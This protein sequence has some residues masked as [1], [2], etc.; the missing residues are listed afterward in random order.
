MGKKYFA[1]GANM[2]LVNMSDRCLDSIMSGRCVLNG[3]R[4]I[5]N[6][7]GVASIVHHHTS[8]VYGILWE[9]SQEDE[10]FLDLFE[11]VKGGWYTKEAISVAMI[12]DE[13]THYDVLVYVASNNTPGKPIEDYFQNI[14]HNAME[15]GFPQAYVEYLQSLFDWKRG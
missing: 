2:D 6:H 12:E 3:Y 11:G 14:I 8:N 9:I 10:D 13:T 15:F 4:F 5:I 7:Y 1:Y